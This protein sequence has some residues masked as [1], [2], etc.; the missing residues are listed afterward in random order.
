ML[1]FLIRAE[2][3]IVLLIVF[4]TNTYP[5]PDLI[6][7]DTGMD[8]KTLNTYVTQQRFSKNYFSDKIKLLKEDW[9]HI[10]NGDPSN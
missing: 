2:V 6:L 9:T 7:W 5:A 4:V 3:Y 8:N 10:F 1:D